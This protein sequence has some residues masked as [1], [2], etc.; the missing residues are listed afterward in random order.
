YGHIRYLLYFN[1]RPSDLIQP[2]RQQTLNLFFQLCCSRCFSLLCLRGHRYYSIL[3]GLRSLCCHKQSPALQH[4]RALM[5]RAVCGKFLSMIWLI[6]IIALIMAFSVFCLPFCGTN[7]INHFFCDV[8]Q[9]LRLTC[10]S[11]WIHEMV[12]I[13]ILSIGLCLFTGPFL[14]NPY[15]YII[16]AILKIQTKE[17]QRKAFST[18]SSH[19]TV[20]AL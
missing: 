8:G 4:S 14:V 15:I 19:I 12:E 9:V 6:L 5:S 17:G 2:A 11:A 18:C 16:S 20:V 10:P 3:I 13:L 7:E 1:Y